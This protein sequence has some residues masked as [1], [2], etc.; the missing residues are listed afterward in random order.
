M[1][2]KALISLD[3]PRDNGSRQE[4]MTARRW[5]LFFCVSALVVGAVG[6]LSVV[7]C[8]TAPANSEKEAISSSPASSADPI[9]EYVEHYPAPISEPDRPKPAGVDERERA[10]ELGE[11]RTET[12]ALE[13]ENGWL[14]LEVVRLNKALAEAA[15]EVYSL[16]KKLDAIFKPQPGGE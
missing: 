14:R 5:A 8:A 10:D 4:G 11:A 13:H 7:S 2:D 9:V 12:E 1:L 15:L 16:N 6:S 3:N